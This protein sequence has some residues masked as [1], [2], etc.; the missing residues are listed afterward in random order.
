MFAKFRGV[1]AKKVLFGGTFLSAALLPLISVQTQAQTPA[2]P[3]VEEVV[4]TGSRIV[5]DGY[6]A[7]TPVAVVGVEQLQSGATANVADYVNTMPVFSGS[8]TPQT[9]QPSVSGGTAGVN[10]LNL[11]NLGSNRTLVLFDG[12]RSVPSLA[13]GFVDVNGFPQALISRVDVV[14]GGASSAYGSDAVAGIV[15]FILDKEFTGVKGEV[16]GGITT[17]GDN[18]TW[19]AQLTT[20]LPFSSGRGH[21]LLSG[22]VS[23][24]AG[25]LDGNRKWNLEPGYGTMVNPAYGTGPGQS[26]DVPERLA[27]SQIGGAGWADGAL[28]TAGPLK[29]IAFGQGGVPYQFVYGDLVSGLEMRGGQWKSGQVRGTKGNSIDSEQETRGVFGRLNYDVTETIN[30]F[31]QGSYNFSGVLTRA[32]PQI[33]PANLSVS[34]DNPFL[35]AEIRAR[36][37]SA[38]VT[39][40][41]IGTLHPDLP[42]NYT[43]NRRNIVR[44]VTGANGAFGDSG[45]TWDTYYQFGIARSEE[46]IP[47]TLSKTKFALSM[48]SVRNAA[49]TIVC[50][51]TL[52]NPNNGCVP[53]NPFGIGLNGQAAIDWIGIYM[54]RHQKMRQD[55][56]AV[57]F[58]GDAFELP[59][60]PVSVAFG[61]EWRKERI[62]GVAA[63]VALANDGLFGNS[64]PSFGEYNVKEAY[65]ETV[66]PLAKDEDWADSFE[67]NGA[68]RATDYSQSGFVATWKLGL[69]YQPVED[70]RFR[71]TRSRDIRAPNLNEYFAG[72]TSNT[73]TVLDRFNNNAPTSYQGFNQGNPALNPEKADAIGIGA[74]YSPSFIPGL[75]ASVDYF[76][77][78]IKDAIGT[79]NAQT[80]VDYCFEGNTAFCGAI[81]RGLNAGGVQ[82]ITRIL[83]QPF[84]LALQQVRGLDLEST[85]RFD[86]AD[87]IDGWEGNV[88][89]RGMASRV[90]K[91]YQDNTVNPPEERAGAENPKWRYSVSLNYDLH[92]ITANLTARGRSQ[93]KWDDDWIQCTAQCPVSNPTNIT[94]N[95]NLREGTFY[96]DMSLNYDLAEED[97]TWNA[98]AFLN[99]RNIFDTDPARQWPGPAGNSFRSILAECG[100]GSDC[101]GRTLRVGVRFS[102]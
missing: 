86:L 6:Q 51:S 75:T 2:G 30:V 89:F 23:Y 91:D 70:I 42:G 46:D 72:G 5:R 61:G 3:V 34:R 88:T 26:R 12:Q 41:T 73:N 99:V 10:A 49:G 20:G 66:V 54:W 68:V 96:M 90:L 47:Y 80:I 33:N 48:D 36:A 18:E 63:D 39:T 21:F 67:L 78:K 98:T 77:V 38:G 79:V 22:E 55:V 87:V 100:N 44:W 45:W 102:R 4:V 29:G 59:A 35:P 81:Q 25:I 71:I 57:N 58:G 74:V 83:I 17:H 85:Y 62:S 53:Y 40:F 1:S 82:V 27:L 13:T 9:S 31:L 50:R 60:G 97:A 24:K 76:D 56:A 19:Q 28:I 16:S 8:A 32:L 101:N 7:P 84:N 37:V 95:Q 14:T 93:G 43:D 65:L 64:L 11:R 69:V 92:P 94:I 52:T 15:N